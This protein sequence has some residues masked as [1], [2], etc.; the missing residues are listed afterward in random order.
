MATGAIDW[1]AIATD[2]RFQVMQRRKT[3]FLAGLMLLAGGYFFLLP[4]GAALY[5]EFYRIRVFGAINIGLLFALSEFLMAWLVAALYLRRANR[6]FD[7]LTDAINAEI[8]ARHRL[9]VQ[10]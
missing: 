1:A 10:P 2:P 9:R 5:P 6:E 4:L 8:M 7:R 3:R